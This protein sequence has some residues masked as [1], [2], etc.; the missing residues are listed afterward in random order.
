[1]LQPTTILAINRYYQCGQAKFI[2]VFEEIILKTGLKSSSLR[3]CHK[4]YP[5]TYLE[6]KH[7]LSYLILN[8]L[9]QTL[10]LSSVDHNVSATR[11]ECHAKVCRRLTWEQHGIRLEKS[12]Q[13]QH[14]L[15][16]LT[17]STPV[18]TNFRGCLL[19]R[20]SQSHFTVERSCF[21]SL[22]AATECD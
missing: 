13:H 10:P 2:R 11:A 19:H 15:V 18:E 9:H 4:I 14:V 21:S 22:S 17:R 16:F 12:Y 7:P 1:M 8:P 5:E 20:L 3:L 6:T